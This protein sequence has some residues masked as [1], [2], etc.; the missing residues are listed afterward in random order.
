[1]RGLDWPRETQGKLV[2]IRSGGRIVT[3][4][5]NRKVR[6]G[7]EFGTDRTIGCG[8]GERLE[9]EEDE[10]EDEAQSAT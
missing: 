9:W 1:M 7:L 2:F 4:S 5:M 3:C 6:I 8:L 10:E